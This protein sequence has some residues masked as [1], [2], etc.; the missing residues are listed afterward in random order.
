MGPRMMF[1]Q[2]NNWNGGEDCLARTGAMG[3]LDNQCN[4]PYLCLCQWPG[5]TSDEFRLEHGPALTQRAEE[6]FAAERDQTVRLAAEREQLEERAEHL[7]REGERQA[8]RAERDAAK[9]AGRMRCQPKLKASNLK[10]LSRAPRSS[11][12]AALTAPQQVQGGT[13]PVPGGRA[14]APRVRQ[15]RWHARGESRHV[16][17]YVTPKRCA[18]LSRLSRCFVISL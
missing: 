4:E 13:P 9:T 16:G 14:C 1:T 12:L 6:A 15:P 17:E 10:S 18:P 7:I 8:A 11:P 3:Y 5:R 2:P